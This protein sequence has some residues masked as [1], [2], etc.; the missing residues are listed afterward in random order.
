MRVESAFICFYISPALSVDLCLTLMGVDI[1]VP[2]TL[3]SELLP[4]IMA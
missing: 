2:N 4:V 1:A 3:M